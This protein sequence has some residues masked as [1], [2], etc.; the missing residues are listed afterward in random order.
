[1]AHLLLYE[2]CGWLGLSAGFHL[3]VLFSDVFSWLYLLAGPFGAFC[4]PSS[5]FLRLSF[6]SSSSSCPH[7]FYVF[8][9]MRIRTRGPE[10]DRNLHGTVF[11]GFRGLLLRHGN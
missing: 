3:S 6:S 11:H 4:C 2:L 8:A 9:R 10:A 5:S 1:M 7:A